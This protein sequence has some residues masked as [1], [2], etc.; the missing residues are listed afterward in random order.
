MSPLY[1]ITNKKNGLDLSA[2]MILI[3]VILPW[4]FIPTI[5]NIKPKL[6]EHVLFSFWWIILAIVPIVFFVINTRMVAFMPTLNIENKF[7]LISSYLAFYHI[8][9]FPY[10]FTTVLMHCSSLYLFIAC[11]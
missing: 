3:W 9:R 11:F 7:G 10:F 4:V 6:E 5:S 2:N 8:F 1:C